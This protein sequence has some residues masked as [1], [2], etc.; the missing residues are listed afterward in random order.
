[1]RRNVLVSACAVVATCALGGCAKQP[2][3]SDLSKAPP[4]RRVTVTLLPV[5]LGESIDGNPLFVTQLTSALSKSSADVQSEY[6]ELN[7]QAFIASVKQRDAILAEIAR[8]RALKEGSATGEATPATEAAD[9]KKDEDSKGSKGSESVAKSLGATDV[10]QLTEGVRSIA[11]GLIEEAVTQSGF[12]ARIG[13][14][15]DLG[16]TSAGILIRSL[17]DEYEL[18]GAERARR[19]QEDCEEELTRLHAHN[20]FFLREFE[21]GAALVGALN[22]SVPAEGRELDP[23]WSRLDADLGECSDEALLGEAQ[24]KLTELIDSVGRAVQLMNADD[25]AGARPGATAPAPTFEHESRRREVLRHLGDFY[26]WS[27]PVNRGYSNGTLRVRLELEKVTRRTLA[28][29]MGV[30]PQVSG[31][32]SFGMSKEYTAIVAYLDLKV[33]LPTPGGG[34]R[35]EVYSRSAPIMFIQEKQ[36]AGKALLGLFSFNVNTAQHV[37]DTRDGLR[38]VLSRMRETV[39]LQSESLLWRG[40]VLQRANA[41]LGPANVHEKDR[42]GGTEVV[43]RRL[44]IGDEFSVY[45]TDYAGFEDSAYIDREQFRQ[46]VG[47]KGRFV[48]QFDQ[49]PWFGATVTGIGARTVRFRLDALPSHASLPG[50]SG[51]VVGFVPS[52]NAVVVEDGRSVAERPLVLLRPDQH[53]DPD[54]VDGASC[55]LLGRHHRWNK[56]LCGDGCPRWE[57]IHS[58]FHYFDSETCVTYLLETD[59]EDLPSGAL[60]A[61]WSVVYDHSKAELDKAAP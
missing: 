29:I 3:S 10:A 13:S 21:A 42:F 52:S 16:D 18:I 41:A 30:T 2:M 5:E 47:E 54:Y 56:R 22:S 7:D 61:G 53:A 36:A 48:V 8:Q 24:A 55:G 60:R 4:A 6:F 26:A 20:V 45:Y 32:A 37:Y 33:I 34:V 28:S 27:R 59:G 57:D 14:M 58:S 31:N 51:S 44:M 40:Q 39:L 50:S 9:S 25:F 43:Y 35:D 23:G 12:L 15:D 46:F 38:Q 19:G 11:Q 1:M 17:R 49:Q